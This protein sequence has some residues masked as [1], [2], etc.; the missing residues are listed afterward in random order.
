MATEIERKFLVKGDFM[1]YVKKAERIVQ[2]YMFA[3]AEKTCRIR[4]HGEKG[5]LTIKGQSDNLGISRLEF[6]Y[7]I[8]LTDAEAL[9]K[10]CSAGLIDKVR[11]YIPQG[12]H[13]W[14]VD[15]FHDSNE[16]LVFAELELT[17]ADEVVNPPN[18]LGKEV[19]G[20]KR[21]YNA[22]L[23]S[24]PYNEWTEEEKKGL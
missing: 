20:I 1:P 13:T 14:E 5:F 11:H 4:I 7:E 17:S 8:P 18:W 22:V 10:L 3:S 19:T 2:G 15:V 12:S 9:L 23:S 21:Y 16:G 6:E 24:H